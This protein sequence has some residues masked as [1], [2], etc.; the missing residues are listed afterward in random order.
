MMSR[1]T[2]IADEGIAI[3]PFKQVQLASLN[4]ILTLA[5]AARCNDVDDPI[6][7]GINSYIH[8]AMIYAGAAGDLGS[9]VPSLAWA[10]RLRGTEKKLR[11][12]VETKRDPIYG[13]LIQEALKKEQDS[14]AK[15]MYEMKEEGLV[16]E[17]DI[18]VFMSKKAMKKK[19]TH[20]QSLFSF[21][22]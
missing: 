22:R 1:L 14:L 13:M 16:D 5:V 8:Q 7:L 15:A 20:T 12:F 3:N 21:Y 10:E 18:H 4:I 11:E 19:H 17:D 9:F 2:K 6:F